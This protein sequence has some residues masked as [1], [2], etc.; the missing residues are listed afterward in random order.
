[1][2]RTSTS[3]V[4]SSSTTTG[5]TP[6]PIGTAAHHQVRLRVIRRPAVRTATTY[7]S[8]TNPSSGGSERTTQPMSRE[9]AASWTAARSPASRISRDRPSEASAATAT[10]ATS[11]RARTTPSVM[12][13]GSSTP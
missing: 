3:P 2:P 7:I 8:A 6:A 1:M 12:S 13:T 9:T 11:S 10:A 4:S 5:T